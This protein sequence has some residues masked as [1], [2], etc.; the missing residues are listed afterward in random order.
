MRRA[1]ATGLVLG[2]A[3][4]LA[5]CSQVAQLQPVAGAEIS[6]VRA[7]T[8]T[9]LVQRQVPIEVAPVC[10]FQD[11]EFVCAGTAVGG[12]QI[13]ARATGRE[14]GPG[15]LGDPQ[16]VYPDLDLVVQVAGETLYQGPVVDVFFEA[17]QVEQ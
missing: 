15:S 7:A 10:E 14:A 2:V 13:T 11:P 5:G 4:V 12:A 3:V 16:A 8:N 6:A 9:I 17:G 1:A